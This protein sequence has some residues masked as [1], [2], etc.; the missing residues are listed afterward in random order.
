MGVSKKAV[1]GPIAALMLMSLGGLLLHYRIHPIAGP[2]GKA[3]NLIPFIFLLI[4]SFALPVLFYF[5]RTVPW[6]YVINVATVVVGTVTMAWHS[7]NNWS[8]PV[9]VK[10]VLLF[11]TLADILILSAKLPLGHMILRHFYPAKGKE[12]AS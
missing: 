5:R 3:F 6:A 10:N 4:T 11:S 9:T 7:Y 2:Q 12:A 1:L 8:L